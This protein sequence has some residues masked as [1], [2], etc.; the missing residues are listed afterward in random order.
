VSSLKSWAGG[1]TL[2]DL[3]EYRAVATPDERLFTWWDGKSESVLTYAELSRRAKTVAAYVL[4]STGPGARVILLSAPGLNFV[5]ALFGCFYAGVVAVPAYPPRGPRGFARLATMMADSGATLALTDSADDGATTHLLSNAGHGAVRVL[6]MDSL[7]EKPMGPGADSN[8]PSIAGDALALL[9]YTSGSTDTPR[10]VRISHSNLMANCAVIHERFEHT[11]GTRGLIWLPPYHDMGLV[12]GILQPVFSGIEAMLMAPLPVVQQ[13]LRWLQAISRFGA[14]VS[15]APN[16]AYELCVRRITPEERSNLDLRCWKVAF[17]GAEP[18]RPETV[19]RF[20]EAF[21]QSGFDPKAI[22]PCYGLAE[23]T[24]FVTGGPRADHVKFLRVNADEEPQAFDQPARE[25]RPRTVVSCGTAPSRH[26]VL[27]VDSDLRTVC[28]DGRCGEIWIAG[29]SV[30]QGY[31]EMPKQT[32]EVFEARLRDGRGPYLRTGDL[33]LLHE[34]NLY[35]TGRLKDLLV[36]RGRNYYP[37]DIEATVERSHEAVRF[38]GAAVFSI[39]DDGETKLVL[40]AEIHPRWKAE[41]QKIVAAI[42]IGVAEEHDIAAHAVVLLRPGAVPRTS[43]GKI[44]RFECRRAFLE[45]SFD[46]IASSVAGDGDARDAPSMRTLRTMNAQARSEALESY[47]TAFVAA[48]A[49]VSAGEVDQTASL[50]ALGFDSFSMVLLRNECEE[51]WNAV[52]SLSEMLGG[53][54]TLRALAV[55][56]ASS[57]GEAPVVAAGN[58][59][60][61]PAMTEGQRAL[62]FLDRALEGRA[63]LTLAR[64]FAIQSGLEASILRRALGALLVRHAVLRSCFPDEGGG[65]RV[66]DRGETLDWFRETDARAWD[67][68]EMSRRLEE[69]AARPFDLA[70]GNSIFPWQERTGERRR[71]VHYQLDGDGSLKFLASTAATSVTVV[72]PWCELTVEVLSALAEWAMESPER[73]CGVLPDDHSTSPDLA[74]ESS[75]PFVLLS[76]ASG[77]SMLDKEGLHTISVETFTGL[78]LGDPPPAGLAITGHGGEHCITIGKQWVGTYPEAALPGRCLLPSA[79]R[80]RAIFLNTCG[81]LRLADSVVPNTYSLAYQLYAQGRA[82]I[83]AFRNQFTFCEAP[84]I[85]AHDVLNGVQLGRIVNRLNRESLKRGNPILSYQLLGEATDVVYRGTGESFSLQRESVG[86]VS[87]GLLRELVRFK[88]IY[89]TL[90]IWFEHSLSVVEGHRE[91][92]NITRLVFTAVHD[93]THSVMSAEDLIFL[94]HTAMMAIRRQRIALIEEFSLFTLSGVWPQSLCGPVSSAPR[95]RLSTC[96]HC[97]GRSMWHEA[98]PRDSDLLTLQSEDCD[99]CGAI[100]DTIGDLPGPCRIDAILDND[101][102]H[103]KVPPLPTASV[104]IIVVHRGGSIPHEVWPEEGGIVRIPVMSIPF[105]GKTTIAASRIGPDFLSFSYT[106]LFVFPGSSRA[107]GT[108]SEG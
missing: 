92:M 102:I 34:G 105:R 97:G 58:H 85:F 77:F 65:P 99:R 87:E 106:T 69:E 8:C 108:V 3:L 104:G 44:Q 100:S 18:I 70:R 48:R 40:L 36:L 31:W 5:T 73:G 82:V 49:G 60:P 15:G 98:K 71:S 41:R 101:E 4:S 86:F 61:E 78:L 52:I 37:H 90:G 10:G 16:F 89:E 46:A 88:K 30:A 68:D 9:Q 64:A 57:L 63:G 33:G 45:R 6:A 54:T 56:V 67:R 95:I 74:Y 19:T 83:G 20:A 96:P 35:V 66:V 26:E 14:S 79:L 43:S 23:S 59:E 55:R 32:R 72:A 29:P 42:R 38:G 107:T 12:G 75:R 76:D 51:R 47:L 17:T 21:A 2:A 28:D 24:L 1:D 22:Y 7:S 27:I 39:E 80:S 93:A 91:F 62:W 53:R 81:S 11:R 94:E 13:P 25:V 50:L 103:V 84:L